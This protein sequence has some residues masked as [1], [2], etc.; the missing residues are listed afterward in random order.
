MKTILADWQAQGITSVLH[1]KRGGYSNQTKTL[2]ALAPK[3]LREGFQS[4]F[5]IGQAT[6]CDLPS[7]SVQPP[8]FG[9]FGLGH[10]CAD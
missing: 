5:P 8:L 7:I 2:C 9:P 3:R 4:E 6:A 1:E 10:D